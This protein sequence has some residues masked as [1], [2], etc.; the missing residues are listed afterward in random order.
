[1]KASLTNS[2]WLEPRYD[3]TFRR[4]LAHAVNDS[5]LRGY[6]PL[7]AVAWLYKT[8][9]AE[10]LYKA[11]ARATPPPSASG[12]LGEASSLVWPPPSGGLLPPPKPA[13]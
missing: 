13:T 2:Q 4:E 6:K 5:D 12:Y 9:A 7:P 11:L 1:M 3:N 10:H 8:D